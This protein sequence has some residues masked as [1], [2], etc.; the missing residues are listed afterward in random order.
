MVIQ[1]FL[2]KQPR[3]AHAHTVGF[4]LLALPQNKIYK[5][6]HFPKSPL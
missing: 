4:P 3:K 2:P 6:T 1:L 5:T